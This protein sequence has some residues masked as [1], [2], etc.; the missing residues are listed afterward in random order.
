V[1][2]KAAVLARCWRGEPTA[3][4]DYGR[5][6]PGLGISALKDQAF[7][8]GATSHTYRDASETSAMLAGLVPRNPEADWAGLRALQKRRGSPGAAS[9]AASRLPRPRTQ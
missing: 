8:P 6:V 2:D 3:A 5:G 4:P 1:N 7:V 9:H